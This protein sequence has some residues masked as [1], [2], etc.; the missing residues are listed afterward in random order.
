MKDRFDLRFQIHP[1]HRLGHPVSHGRHSKHPH[2]LASRFGIS[3]VFYRRRKIR[4]RRQAVRILYRF[5]SRSAWNCAIDSLSAPAAPLF[6][7][8]LAS[9]AASTSAAWKLLI[10]PER[11]EW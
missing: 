4:A 3:T 2:P 11:S 1:H 5:R 8:I 6:A 9:P 10:N 7:L